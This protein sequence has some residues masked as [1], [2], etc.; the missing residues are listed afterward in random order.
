MINDTSTLALNVISSV[1][2]ANQQVNTP[3]KGHTMSLRDS[4]VTVMSTSISPAVESVMPLLTL[5]GLGNLLPDSVKKLLVAMKEFRGYMDEIV[6][7]E[8]EKAAARSSR[9]SS[10]EEEK[11]SGGH[12]NLISTL[13]R[14]SGEVDSV[15][16]DGAGEGGGE[17]KSKA[18][19]SDEELRGNIFI[20]TV[21]GLESTAIT[22]SYALA[23]LA[24][25]PEV[26]DWV[27]EE[28]DEV[29]SNEQEEELEY[30]RVFPRLKRVMAVMCI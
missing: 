27:A 1:A 13:I 30:S 18:K 22:L 11:R 19:L 3:S 29:L 10:S 23:L 20:F 21:G 17:K 4:L 12:L 2:F 8:R 26:Q 24:I 5:S 6:E 28:L 16:D 15:G 7:R 25:Y 9:S 14:A